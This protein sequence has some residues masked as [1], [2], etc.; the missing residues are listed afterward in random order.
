M[1]IMIELYITRNV[2]LKLIFVYIILTCLDISTGEFTAIVEMDSD[3]FTLFQNSTIWEKK[4]VNP[5]ASWNG[6]RISHSTRI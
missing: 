4:Y 5:S 3:E 6:V 2:I 1:I